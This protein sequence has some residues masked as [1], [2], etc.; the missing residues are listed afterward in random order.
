V[1]VVHERLK[2]GILVLATGGI[3]GVHRGA[4]L[5]FD[6]S[7]DLLELARTS[8]AVVC[9]GAKTILDLRLTR[10]RQSAAGSGPERACRGRRFSLGGRGRDGCRRLVWPL[11]AIGPKH[12]R[13][14][15]VAS[16]GFPGRPEDALPVFAPV[17]GP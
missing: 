2:A 1:A 16:Q 8:V 15:V 9:A 4:E 3:G 14:Q 7:A 17:A 12:G 13:Y 5:G 10:G 6:V 11:A